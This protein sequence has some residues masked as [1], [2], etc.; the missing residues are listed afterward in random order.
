MD[1]TKLDGHINTLSGKKLSLIKPTPA[2]IDIHDISNGLANKGHFAGQTPWY[3]SI[4]EHSTLV[5]DYLS[6][7]H[8]L[9]KRTRNLYLAA[10]LHDASEAYIGDMVK[11]LKVLIPAFKEV[12]DKITKAIF[13]R[14]NVPFHLLATIKQYDISAQQL[15][16]E[17]FFS[18]RLSKPKALKFLSPAEANINFQNYFFEI[19][20]T[21]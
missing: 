2:T 3:F 8:K 21:K 14:Y 7:D 11:P 10:I 18:G 12:E 6:S 16:A 20:N 15:E 13:K 1:I 19:L 17:C 5:V 9:T 4:A